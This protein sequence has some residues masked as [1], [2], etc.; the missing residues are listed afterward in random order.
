MNKTIIFCL[1]GKSTAGKNT[2]FA[3]IPESNHVVAR[4]IPMTTRTAKPHEK[5]GIHYTF[6]PKSIF[7]KK[8]E[9][10]DIMEHRKEVIDRK[11]GKKDVHYYGYPFPP[12]DIVIVNG[13]RELF[14]KLSE[15][16]EFKVV[17]IYITIPEEERLFRMIRRESRLTPPDYRA[18]ARQFIKD[19]EILSDEYLKQIGIDESN[20]FVNI[21][22][23][24]AAKLINEYINKKIISLRGEV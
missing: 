22:R 4:M 17:P 13:T 7:M 10:G 15:Y 16:P 1:L 11:D 14:D 18:V 19:N 5:N 3:A 21:D 24:H 12:S 6:I 20:T 23:N 2:M 9:S 8:L